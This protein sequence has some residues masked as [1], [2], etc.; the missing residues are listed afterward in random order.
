MHSF[1]GSVS[2]EGCENQPRSRHCER[3]KGR[4]SGNP[5]VP[6]E[7]AFFA[8]KN[9][10][11]SPTATRVG[12]FRWRLVHISPDWKMQRQEAAERRFLRANSVID[13]MIRIAAAWVVAA[14]FACCGA[15]AIGQEASQQQAERSN[16]AAFREV[17]DEVGRTIRVPQAIHRIVSLAPSITETLY[18]LGLQDELVGDTEYCDFPPDARLKP[19]VGGAINPSLEAIAALHPDVVLVTKSLNR[20]DTVRALADLGIPSYATDPHTV[21]EILASTRRLADLL[22]VSDSGATV[23]QGLERR[24]ETTRQRVVAFPAKRVLFVVWPQ[25]LISVG[26]G[27]FLAD[28][29]VQAG[30]VSIIDSAQEW[31]Q[32]S[33][34]AVVHEQPDFLIFAESHSSDAPTDLNALLALPGWRIMEAAKNHRVAL[35]SDAI[36]RPAP[37]I[38]SVIEDLARKL[39]PEAFGDAPGMSKKPSERTV[40][41]ITLRTMPAAEPCLWS[42]GRWGNACSL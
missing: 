25:P 13:R 21:A 18:T 28:A 24:L 38:V 12:L 27:T 41:D 42:D 4:K 34:E 11:S 33:L 35:V 7:E 17:T 10:A 3:L 30:G 15:S 26:K 2:G 6:R 1:E 20:M 40:E 14:G 23:T 36:N 29:L 22:G 9:A 5:S 19:K 32:L 39:H 31:P 8:R 37:R 16:A